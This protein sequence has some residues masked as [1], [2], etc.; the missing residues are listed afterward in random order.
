M[1]SSLAKDL[2][3]VKVDRRADQEAIAHLT[4]GFARADILKFVMACQ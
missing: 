2:A 4:N 1:V 3:G